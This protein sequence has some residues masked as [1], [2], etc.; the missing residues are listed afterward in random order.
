MIKYGNM[1]DNSLE[2]FIYTDVNS[3]NVK[4]LYNNSCSVC[5]DYN[6]TLKVQCSC[7]CTICRDCLFNWIA[8][9]NYENIFSHVVLTPCPNHNCK[10]TISL[11]WIYENISHK[12]KKCLSEILTRKFTNNSSDV[13]KCP[14]KFCDYRGWVDKTNKC[15]IPLKCQL[16]KTEWVDPSLVKFQFFYV[17]YLF[18]INFKENFFLSLTE[19]NILLSTKPCPHCGIKI[20]KFVGCDHVSCTSCGESFCYNCMSD[21]QN[22]NDFT[23][24]SCNYKYIVFGVSVSLVSYNAV[25]K[26]LFTFKIMMDILMFIIYLI[27]VDII[28]IIIIGLFC[29]FAYMTLMDF[30]SQTQNHVFSKKIRF[31]TAISDVLLVYSLVYCCLEYSFFLTGLLYF[32]CELG[33]GVLLYFGTYLLMAIIG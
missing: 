1:N 19:I 21:H 30:F 17:F 22:S 26:I 32:I 9:K 5:D 8:T 4:Q 12:N 7:S 20:N 23:R 18:L 29:L 24:I 27:F 13:I 11:N 10:N 28:G 33:L 15:S 16:C 2:N 31:I 6:D 14:N 3:Q 25:V